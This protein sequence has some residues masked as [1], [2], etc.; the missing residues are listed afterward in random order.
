SESWI[1]S[2]IGVAVFVVAHSGAEME[3]GADFKICLQVNAIAL[4]IA[5][6]IR[7]RRSSRSIEQHAILTEIIAIF[8]T[9]NDGMTIP[10][11][12]AQLNFRS[13]PFPRLLLK[14]KIRGERAG[15]RVTNLKIVPVVIRPRCHIEYIFKAMRVFQRGIGAFIDGFQ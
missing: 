4:T 5:A 9:E 6:Y 2:G 15:D 14:K 7:K 13:P 8:R 1:P 3:I 11:A 10:D 12:P